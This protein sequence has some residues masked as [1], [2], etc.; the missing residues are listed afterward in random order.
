LEINPLASSP[1]DMLRRLLLLKIPFFHYDG[2]RNM[3]LFF[4]QVQ[5]WF[6]AKHVKQC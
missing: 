1:Y 5:R 2:K 4:Q 3:E 6:I